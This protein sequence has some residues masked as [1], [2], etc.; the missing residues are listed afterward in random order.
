MTVL[1]GIGFAVYTSQIILKPVNTH[2]SRT[3]LITDKTV[4]GLNF[5]DDIRSLPL[6]LNNRIVKLFPH[7]WNILKF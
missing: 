6:P 4:I 3:L 2:V 5:F 1:L 7:F